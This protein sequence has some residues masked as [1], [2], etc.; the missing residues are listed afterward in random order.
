MPAG[1]FISVTHQKCRCTG[2]GFLRARHVMEGPRGRLTTRGPSVPSS[3]PSGADLREA[4][5]YYLMLRRFFRS[6]TVRTLGAF[7]KTVVTVM[8]DVSSQRV[9]QVLARRL[10]IGGS[11]RYLVIARSCPPMRQRNHCS[12]LK[13]IP[14]M[15][16]QGSRPLGPESLQSQ[17]RPRPENRLSICR[18]HVIHRQRC[19]PRPSS[20]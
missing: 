19:T 7:D 8:R 3:Q 1:F 12:S 13:G 17:T 14:K 9:W 20:A 5:P 4:P 11:G 18:L 6:P 2:S 15:K 16:L 10:E